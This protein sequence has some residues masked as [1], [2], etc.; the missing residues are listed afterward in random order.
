MESDFRFLFFSAENLI[1][2]IYE[3]MYIYTYYMQGVCLTMGAH[4]WLHKVNLKLDFYPL[5]LLNRFP[6]SPIT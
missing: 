6:Q 5:L 1:Y 3:Y 2:I 4:S